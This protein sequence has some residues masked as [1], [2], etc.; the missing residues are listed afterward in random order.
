MH[1]ESDFAMS[2]GCKGLLIFEILE[3]CMQQDVVTLSTPIGVF[4]NMEISY[5]E[6]C[7]YPLNL[8]VTFKISSMYIYFKT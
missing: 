1:L 7:Y 8:I 3:A 4:N 5:V 2:D 6:E